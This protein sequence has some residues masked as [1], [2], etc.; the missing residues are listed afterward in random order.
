M[1]WNNASFVAAE[2]GAGDL[3]LMQEPKSEVIPENNIDNLS[4]LEGSICERLLYLRSARVESGAVS[5][6]RGPHRISRPDQHAATMATVF[7]GNIFRT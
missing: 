5:S 6:T 1:S 7:W 3:Q 4:K 2:L